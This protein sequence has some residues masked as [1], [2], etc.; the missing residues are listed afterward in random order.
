MAVMRD[1]KLLE[2]E[3]ARAG[4]P[5]TKVV[6]ATFG[7]GNVMNEALLS[8]GLDIATGGIT[9]FITLWSKTRGTLNVKSL[10]ALDT[11][12]LWLMTRN[13]A[14]ASLADLRP[15]DKI[16]VTAVKVSVHAILL[17]MAAEKMWGIADYTRFDPLTV[18]LPQPDGMA[19][20]LSGAGEVDGHFTA[21]P[22]QYLEAKAPGIH[23][24]TTAE[25][26]LGGPA[27]FVVAWATERFR[28]D[29]P[30][31]YAAFRA[32]LDRSIAAIKA[33]P[34]GA[35]EIYR[36][37]AKGVEAETDYAEMLSDPSVDFTTTPSGTM[38]YL[39]FMQRI[40]SVKAGA[41]SWKDLFFPEL[42]DQPGS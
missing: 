38:R 33:D 20:L 35:A 16:A 34:K 24:V 17:Q 26:I 37:G 9:P 3:V 7:G 28:A 15:S 40:A 39:G 1:R 41:E 5:D 22:F 13:P 4:L 14:V 27:T 21:P 42:H 25:E 18:S 23:R 19:A 2:A 10:G 29:N 30:K 6:W 8:G 36:G 12:P 32:A 11:L 31:L